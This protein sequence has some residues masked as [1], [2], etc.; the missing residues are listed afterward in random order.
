MKY[1]FWVL[2]IAACIGICYLFATNHYLH[3][4]G[5][6]HDEKS[7]HTVPEGFHL[8]PDGTLMKNEDTH[9]AAET[10]E[11]TTIHN[12]NKDVVN[13]DLHARVIELR[14]VNY[15]FD[16]SEIKVKKGETVTI[17]FESTD[18]FHDFVIDELSVATKKVQPGNKT[19]VTF[20]ADTVGIFE[21]YCSVGEHR[22]HG[23]VGKLIVE[24]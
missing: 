18:G 13:L 7:S 5:D 19:S 3:G 6:S 21:Y 10:E 9:E 17:N 16:L 24:E 2:G 8:M 20:T 23:M 1:L 4:H 12:S 15:S 14:G 11:E 22:S